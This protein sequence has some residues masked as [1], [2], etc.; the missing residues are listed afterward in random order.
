MSKGKIVIIILI[1]GLILAL[2]GAVYWRLSQSP[3]PGPGLEQGIPGGPKPLPG[4]AIKV[5]PTPPMDPVSARLSIQGDSDDPT[6]ILKDV[7]NT[8]LT[9]LDQESP[10]I[11]SQFTTP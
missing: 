5:S 1:I 8:D 10:Q 11:E 3:T 7:N 9:N 4:S 2:A 6:A